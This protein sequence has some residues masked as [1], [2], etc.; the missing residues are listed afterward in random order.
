MRA[1]LCFALVSLSAWTASAQDAAPAVNLR[2][3]D[4]AT[5]RI[6]SLRGLDVSRGEGRTTR[7]TRVAANPLSSHGSGVAIGPRLVLTARHVVWSA[8]A[9]VVFQPGSNEPIAARPIY[10]DP[11]RDIAFLTLDEPVSDTLSG[12]EERRL[13]LSERVSVS[14]YPLD[15]R[16]TIPAAASGEVSRVTRNGELHLTMTVNPGHS[17]GPVIDG[18]GHLVGILSARGRMDRGVEGLAIA[19]PMNHILTARG[20]VPQTAPTFDQV[21]RD[22]ARVISVLADV[23]DR[24]LHEQRDTIVPLVRRAVSWE[25]HDADRDALAAALAWNTLLGLLEERRAP[26]I[27]QLPADDREQ[28]LLL[29]NAAGRLARRALE[30]GPHVRRLFPIVR[31]ISLGRTDGGPNDEQ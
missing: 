29:R 12:L 23:E 15:L 9:W 18:E 26:D 31:A 11:D 20:R 1:L 5:V 10:V 16:E 21:D 2:P 7:V 27:E 6:L 13:T 14:G 30:N 19:V 8:N 17:G 4:R 24:P 25:D 22:V 28:A 3:I